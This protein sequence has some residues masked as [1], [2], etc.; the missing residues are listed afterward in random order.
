MVEAIF[1]TGTDTGVGKTVV[2]A[3]LVLGLKGVYWKPVQSGLLPCTDTEWVQRV[4]GLESC[5]FHPEAYRLKLPQSPHLAAREEGVSI[6]LQKIEPPKIR[7]L[8]VEGSGGVLVPINEK[9][10]MID[11]IEQLRMPVLVVARSTLGTIN[12]TLLTLAQL[13]ERQI[14][15]AGVVLN[16]PKSPWNR[17]AIEQYGQVKVVG[18]I[19]PKE[20][21]NRAVLQGIF[22]SFEF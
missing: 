17:Q 22:E 16:G 18:E 9:E 12:H 4:T 5:H 7:P 20:V 8:I 2:S 21:L 10:F 14:P 19:E 6:S 13:K 3:A 15:I 1:V 11:L